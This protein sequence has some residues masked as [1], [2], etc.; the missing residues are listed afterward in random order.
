MSQSLAVKYRP[1]TFESVCGQ[2]STIKILNRQIELKQFKNCY[3][4]CGASGCGKTTA[5]RIFANQINNGIGEPIEVDGASNNGVENVKQIIKSASERAIEGEYKIYIIDEAHMLT[6]Q[7]WNALLKTIEEPPKFT[8]FI[9]CTTDPQ[10][11]PSTIMN[12]VQRFNFTR[13]NSDTIKNRLIYICKSEGFENYTDACDYVSR[14]CNGQMRDAIAT[15]EKCASYSNDLSID[16]VLSVLGDYSYDMMFSLINAT[17]DG[18][19]LDIINAVNKLYNDGADLKLF[20]NQFLNFTLDIQKYIICKSID[21]TK[22][23]TSM[24][25]KLNN[26]INFNNAMQYY[27]Y[28]T[29]KLLELKNMLKTDL[30]PKPTVEVCLLSMCRLQ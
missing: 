5:A 11:I 14:I 2:E 10:K 12:R 15:I 17:I 26:S 7:A 18:K 4:F 13:L 23:P 20:V 6:I 9:F 25:E 30:D 21:I 22:F 3:L 8:I 19:E 1:T 29:K 24:V 27:G 28:I 16:N